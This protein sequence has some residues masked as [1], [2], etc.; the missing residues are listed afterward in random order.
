[1]RIAK[2]NIVLRLLCWEIVASSSCEEKLAGKMWKY[3]TKQCY[4][5][6]CN[7]AAVSWGLETISTTSSS[8][9]SQYVDSDKIC[10]CF[11]KN[12]SQ[13]RQIWYNMFSLL[14]CSAHYHMAKIK[15]WPRSQIGNSSLYVF[16]VVL[17]HLYPTIPLQDTCKQLGFLVSGYLALPQNLIQSYLFNYSS[18]HDALSTKGWVNA[19]SRVAFW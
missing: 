18:K 10:L 6:H 3:Q 9:A 5:T 4:N 16:S 2:L 14:R 15:Q 7:W 8:P 12:N 1:M 17:H 13:F 19:C 11:I